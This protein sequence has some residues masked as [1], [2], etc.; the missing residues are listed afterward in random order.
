MKWL[1][2][3]WCVL[4][5]TQCSREGSGDLAASDDD[6]DTDIETSGD[7]FEELQLVPDN[8]ITEDVNAGDVYYEIW[9]HS[10]TEDA[11]E[12][13][14]D[15]EN[16]SVLKITKD[17]FADIEI[18]PK[19]PSVE[20]SFLLETSQILIMMGSALISFG[21]VMLAF[22]LCRQTLEEKKKKSTGYLGP[23]PRQVT[24]IVKNYKKVP[25]HTAQFLLSQVET[26]IQCGDGHVESEQTHCDP[27]IE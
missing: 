16:D 15:I 27:L 13:S 14:E 18:K 7:D 8:T 23:D 4:V 17:S 6:T 26:G 2:I 22:F 25:M 24:P 9:K 19:P 1:V 12:Y 3:F 21:V 11:Y 5:L 20:D 10:N